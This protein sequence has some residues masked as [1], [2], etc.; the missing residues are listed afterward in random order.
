MP[1]GIERWAEEE[2]LQARLGDIRN[3]RRLVIIAAGA[4]AKP[5]GKVSAVFDNAAE[6]QGAYDFLENKNVKAEDIV[7]AI[8]RRTAQRSKEYPYVYLLEDGSSLTL[9]DMDK[10]KGIGPIG[11]SAAGARGLKMINAIAASPEGVPL[12]LVSQQWWH[13]P[14]G[15][16]PRTKAARDKR[17][18]QDKETQR[19]LDAEQQ[20]RQAYSEQAP[21]CRLWTQKDREADSWPQLLDAVAHSTTQWTTIRASWNRRL[22]SEDAQDLYLW[23]RID[24]QEVA[25]SYALVVRAGKNRQ[26][27]T[28]QMQVRYCEVVLDLR[29][30]RT[31]KRMD[32]KLYVVCTQEVGTTPAGEKPICWR[33]LTTYPVIDLTAAIAVIDGYSQR[34]LVEEFHRAWKSGQCNVEETQL[35]S[36][37]AIIKW[38]IILA[39]VAMRLQRLVYLGRQMPQSAA[40]D[41]FSAAEVQAI[42]ALSAK[43][44]TA[45]TPLSATLTIAEAVLRV[46]RLGGYTGSSSGGPP[47]MIVIAAGRR[48]SVRWSRTGRIC[49]RRRRLA[50][51]AL[52]ARS[53]GSTWYAGCRTCVGRHAQGRD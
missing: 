40:S 4:A 35:R 10:S 15:K 22:K 9:N 28:A 37:E 13:R 11:T 19:W 5:S 33:L 29:D 30:P 18:T 43:A 16:A 34:W 48:G 45:T 12:G 20:A 7:E 1:N 24:E 39:A 49:V 52:C 3:S 42:Q 46:A 2:F 36:K 6:L 44:T 41:E 47:G 51:R 8:S 23:E 38:A 14:E 26:A 53:A 21:Q 17:K 50:P 27:R 25:G 32:A 31:K